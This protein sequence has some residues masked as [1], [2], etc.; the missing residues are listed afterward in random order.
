M[1]NFSD[2]IRTNSTFVKLAFDDLLFAE[3]KCPI[4]E[5]KLPIW[6]NDNYLVYV[7]SGKKIWSSGD[8][9]YELKEGESILV[10]KGA[11]YI[12]QIMDKE[13]CVLI[14]FFPDE[15]LEEV[16][17]EA[18]YK[19]RSV[20]EVEASKLIP[21]E[22]NEP[23]KIFFQSMKSFFS[24]VPGPSRQLVGLKFKELIVQLLNYQSN[25]AL[26]SFFDLVIA[27]P[28]RKFRQLIENNLQFSLGLDEYARMAGM[29]VSSFKRF[30][31]Q[32]YGNS[33]GQYI[34]NRKLSIASFLLK[35]GTKSIQ[36]IAY[37]VGFENPAHFTR[38]F[39]KKYKVSPSRFR[40]KD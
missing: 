32:V 40:E 8:L 16:L 38:M 39:T 7:L 1:K 37:E 25:P 36:E 9:S 34:I 27:S 26:F 12:E 11:H 18:S 29:S 35:K 21:I 4:K 17:E 20:A 30:F 15:F 24:Q 6:S 19:K 14:F 13:F 3:Y 2:H 5:T 31:K 33:P 23:L 28:E 22:M 10:A